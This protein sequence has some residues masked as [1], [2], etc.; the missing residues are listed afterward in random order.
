MA[1]QQD[2][3]DAITW[4]IT[5]FV[6]MT[7]TTTTTTTTATAAHTTTTANHTAQDDIRC[8]S[9]DGS[10]HV[11]DEVF[12]TGSHFVATIV[13]I[14]GTALLIAQATIHHHDRVWKIVSFSIYGT[15]LITL[16]LCSTLHHG[17]TTSIRWE[18]RFRMADY[19]AIYPLIAGTFTP[20]CLVFY[21]QSIIGWVF[22]MTVWTISILAMLG[23]VLYFHKIPKWL[24]MTTYLTLGWIGACMSYWLLPVLHISGF[25]VFVLGGLFYTIGGYVF[26]TEQPNPY[27]GIFGFHEIWHLAVIGGAFTHWLLMYCYVLPY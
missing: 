24:S 16:F 17:I 1:M 27:P 20:L 8:R 5:N 9:K 23:T 4:S 15:A 25:A 11:T 21:H 18:Q 2:D 7:T 10:I 19:V 13:S 12:N 6:P 14:L 3:N 22:G 26:I